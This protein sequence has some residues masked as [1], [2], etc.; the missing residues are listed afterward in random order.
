MLQGRCHMKFILRVYRTLMR[1]HNRVLLLI[2]ITYK[3][4]FIVVLLPVFSLA[5]E[6]AMKLWGQSYVTD[7]NLSSFFSSP[8]VLLLLMVTV[9]V[10]GL[11]VL[12]KMTTMLQYTLMDPA[13]TRPDILNL[14]LL[15]FRK[16]YRLLRRDKL[17]LPFT[18]L[19]YM[20]IHLPILVGITL[21][22]RFPEDFFHG[23]SDRLFVKGL[24]LTALLFLGLVFN[25]YFFTLHH[26]LLYDKKLSSGI[27]QSKQ[28]LTGR[29]LSFLGR[30]LIYNLVLSLCS[31]LFYY[32]V[33]TLTALFVYLFTE[34]D[35]VITVFLAIYPKLNF[36]MAI[37][38]GTIAYI[39]N[40]NLLSGYY[41]QHHGQEGP[42]TTVPKLPI[43][44]TAPSSKYRSLTA[45][46]LLLVTLFGILNFYHTIRN[47]AFY[48][49]EALAGIRI[50]SH[51]GFSALA[52]ENTLASLEGA[53]RAHSDYAEIDVQQTRDGHLVLMHDRSLWRTTGL[54]KNTSSLTLEEIKQ[55]DAGSWFG[56]E[57]IGTS[58][59]T[60]EEAFRYCKGRIHLSLDIK[61]GKDDLELAEKLVSLIE[62]YE[63][64]HQCIIS[65]TDYGLLTKIK[66]LNPELRTG[67]IMSAAYGN[68]Y[69]NEFID[70]YS[71]RSDFITKSIVD[72]AHRNGKEIH[73][74][75]VNRVSELERMKALGVDFI[76]TDHPILAREVLFRDGTNDTFIE[77]LNRM[78]TQRS[79]FQ[80][81]RGKVS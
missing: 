8:Y 75:T 65:S 4:F 30:L 52:P 12:L 55:L 66:M 42:N 10:F 46:I 26:C 60:L 31:F 76:I 22:L 25:R 62:Q 79:F 67:L 21:Y 69:R 56:K 58:V 28:L 15:G 1:S 47:D 68:F 6:A 19:L 70:F 73:A 36:Y 11:Y 18:L 9:I 54:N 39:T 80:L 72:S 32:F 81:V 3:I 38:I 35:M 13:N 74:W 45:G 2:D 61:S 50:S 20:L 34:R 14:L 5:L 57:F 48:L 41:L 23:A 24:I 53:I 63:Y 59:P 33:L 77:L 16:T 17:I 51:R 29:I 71:I 43:V 40:L 78:L 37:I 7:R 27:R 49:Q 44:K 64:D